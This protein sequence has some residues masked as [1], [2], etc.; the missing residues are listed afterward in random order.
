MVL[1]VVEVDEA[2]DALVD[3]DVSLLRVVGVALLYE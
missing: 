1:D 2:A 3:L